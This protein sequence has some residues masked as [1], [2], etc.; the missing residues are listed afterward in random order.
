MD[1]TLV[2]ENLTALV[3]ANGSGK[4]SFLRALELFYNPSPRIEIEDFY[5][6]NT[7]EEIIISVTFT[8]LSNE[9]KTLFAKYIQNDELTV[10]RVFQ[11]KDGKMISSYHGSTLQN[12]DF[13]SIREALNI[14]DRGKSAKEAYEALRTKTEYKSL[15]SYTNLNIST[16]ISALQEWEEKNP[17]L[18]TRQRDDGQF[19]GFKSVAHGYLGRFTR[20]LFIPA[21]RDASGDAFEGKGSVL[22]DLMDLVVRSVIANKEALKQLK[23][24][25]Q[26]EYEDI[27][28]PENLI[29]LSSLAEQLTKTLK[30]FV[31][32]SVINLKWLPLEEIN[33]PMPKADV[34]LIEDGYSTTVTRT[35]HGLQRAFIL[36]MLQ[37]LSLAQIV[38]NDED[39]GIS[40]LPNFVLVIEEPELYQHPSRQRHFAQILLQLS[41]GKIPGVAEKTQVIYGTHSP[42][43]V[44]IDRIEQVRLLRKGENGI[45]NP[46][47]TKVISTTLDSIAK[48][49][50]IADGQTGPQYTGQSLLPRL[51]A[52][53]TPWMNEG[54]FADVVVL[55]EGEDD[56]AAI[57][58]YAKAKGYNFESNGI[59]VIPC[60]GKNNLDRPITIFRELGIPVYAIWDGDYENKDAKPEDN[61]RLLRLMNDNVVDWPNVVKDDYSCF[62]V[63]L[64]CTIC[65][66]IGK[67]VFEELLFACQCTYCINKRKHAIKNPQIIS[68]IIKEA[69]NRGCTSKT[70]DKIIEKIL[71]LKKG[72]INV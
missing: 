7:S 51:Q 64:E 70:L 46:K 38:S 21:I 61:H 4:S 68:D 62:K 69:S 31:S 72:D 53:M 63:D 10:E 12:E 57:L 11:L 52:I 35:G 54:F 41:N 42:L 37:H 22:T 71:M 13:N 43:F 60:G 14:K 1:E 26:R 67:E 55:V 3:G 16:L 56:R 30:T 32:D 66:E 25:T 28:N 59:A 39:S 2:C 33:F 34:K 45:G 19:F 18:C 8:Q 47:I 23:E 6:A 17:D 50:W 48:I 36:T 58:G 20:L 65:E 49:I 27:M 15:P 5:N 29:E 40:S 24:K 44:D 9:A